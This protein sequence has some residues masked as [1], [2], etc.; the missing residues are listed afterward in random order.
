M[1]HDHHSSRAVDP[2]IA[3]VELKARLGYDSLRPVLR[4][5]ADHALLLSQQ[6]RGL[7]VHPAATDRPWVGQ[8]AREAG[9]AIGHLSRPDGRQLVSVLTDELGLRPLGQPGVGGQAGDGLRPCMKKLIK[10][11]DRLRQEG[12]GLPAQPCFPDRPW[13]AQIAREAGIDPSRLYRPHATDLLAALVSELGLEIAEERPKPR[14]KMR[15]VLVQLQA[16]GAKLRTA[17]RGL[18]CRMGS[19]R[20]WTRKIAEAVGVS[21]SQLS[22]KD[23]C[24]ALAELAAEL[25]LEPCGEEPAATFL[26]VGELTAIVMRERERELAAKQLDLKV[27]RRELA[28]VRWGM[29]RLTTEAGGPGASAKEAVEDALAECTDGKYRQELRRAAAQLDALSADDA[30][31]KDFFS[32]LKAA[33]RQ[34]GTSVRGVAIQASVPPSAVYGWRYCSPS[35]NNRPAVTRIEGVLGLPDGTLTGRLKHAS[36]Q[37]GTIRMERYPPELR[38]ANNAGLR[39]RVRALLKP[40]DF[41]LEPDAFQARCLEALAHLRSLPTAEERRAW[42]ASRKPYALKELPENLEN[43]ISVIVRVKTLKMAPDKLLPGP[44][45]WLAPTAKI[46]RDSLRYLFGYLAM[47]VD[48]KPAADPSSFTLALLLLPDV[49]RSF[50]VWRTG[51]LGDGLDRGLSRFDHGILGRWRSWVE[52]E[53]GLIY[54]QPELADRLVPIEGVVTAEEIAV[55]R[56]DW[57]AACAKAAARYRLIEQ[58]YRPDRIIDTQERVEAI[59]E[60]PD[61][62]QAFRTMLIAANEHAQIFVRGTEG[63][64]YATRDLFYLGIQAQCGFRCSTLKKLLVDHLVRRVDGYHL[65]VPRELFKNMKSPYFRA[66]TGW[67]DLER[68][69]LDLHGLYAVIDDYLGLARPRLMGEAQHPWMFPTPDGQ[70]SAGYFGHI[71]HKVSRAF[72]AHNPLQDTGMV[73]VKPFGNHRFRDI[74]ATGVLKKTGSLRLAADAIADTPDMVLQIYGRYLPRERASELEQALLDGLI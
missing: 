58:S 48:G 30:L 20:P 35:E 40:D 29:K 31:P 25:G 42:I 24:A 23:A 34:A 15:P 62:L 43:E 41:H 2:V 22:R 70:P 7:P 6:G 51:R 16:Y 66:G 57:K 49:I 64:A 63:W 8:L 11:T 53:A 71:S 3:G 54:Q 46:A 67:R 13:L 69:L 60:S 59:L 5:V 47:D 14:R 32:A 44:K 38:G 21:Q 52:P 19:D 72:L 18:P 68:R 26:T 39:T 74:L 55:I 12:R 65:Q 9:V 73:G 28:N 50:I 45:R 4:A 10:F 33:C 56:Q 36:R 1:Q 37:G 17:G 27:L 61:P